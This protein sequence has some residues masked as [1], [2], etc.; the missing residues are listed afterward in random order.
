P[1]ESGTPPPVCLSRRIP[2]YGVW[3][4]TVCRD[5]PNQLSNTFLFP[6]MIEIKTYQADSRAVLSV[7]IYHLVRKWIAGRHIVGVKHDPFSLIFH[8]VLNPHFA[9][10]LHPLSRHKLGRVG[11]AAHI[12]Q[13][14][15]VVRAARH[16]RAARYEELAP[17][18]SGFHNSRP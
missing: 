9:G 11:T 14:G 1:G 10:D 17:H 6:H 5:F 13:E 15:G 8:A 18:P 12:T 7:K 4:H 3:P 16:C 2:Y